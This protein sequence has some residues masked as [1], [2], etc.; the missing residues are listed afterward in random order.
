MSKLKQ[1]FKPINNETI[2][3][4]VEDFRQKNIPKRYN[5]IKLMNYLLDDELDHYISISNRSDGKSFNYVDFL[6]KFAIDYDIGFMF[7][8]RHHTVQL[9]GQTL[10]QKIIDTSS[11]DYNPRDFIFINNEFYK[12]LIYKDKAIALITDLNKA[13]DLK[14]NSNYLKDFP[15]MVYDEFLALEGD[16]L[17]DEW[18]RLKTIYASV[19]RD[20]EIP[21]IKIPK[22]L[23]LG[24]AVNFSSPVLANLNIFN[25]LERHP[26]N[27]VR[28]YEN[29]V[30]EF[31]RNEQAN[32]ERNLRAFDETKDSMTMGEFDINNHNV[33]NENDRLRINKN[34][35]YIY[36]KLVKEYLKITY[37]TDTYECMLSIITYAKK[38][39]FNLLIKDNN[40][41]SIYLNE[42]Y[43]DMEHDRKYNKDL[44]LF[45]NVYSKDYILSDMHNLT[46]LRINKII[47]R[48]MTDN[49]LDNFEKREKVYKENYLE[50]TKKALYKK[51]F[52]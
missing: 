17:P 43:Y 42:N 24:N 37:N 13:T 31:N 30:L 28:K 48:H 32:E 4:Y 50:N 35:S 15:I 47:K 10:M 46:E 26:M 22:V 14:Y 6:I 41:E 29:V 34:P 2:H 38:Y 52:E 39:D 3:P 45:D 19:N 12:T 1:F 27:E 7:I 44:F 36:I 23:Y 25:I 8:V 5:Q 11:N 21:Y 9:F 51:F 18:E 40:N 49:K 33:A 16:Y 20:D